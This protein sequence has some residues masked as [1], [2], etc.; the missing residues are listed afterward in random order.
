MINKD[1]IPE[2]DGHGKFLQNLIDI[3]SDLPKKQKQL[4]DYMIEHY[5]TVGVLTLS[6]LAEQANVGTTTAMRLINNLGYESYLDIKKD[7]LDASIQTTP[8]AWWHLQESFKTNKQ[9][10]HTLVEVFNEAKSILEQT[11]T[12]S[13]ITNFDKVRQLILNSNRV[14]ILG[15]R[16][17]KALANYFGYLLEEFYPKVVQLSNETEFVYDRL[18]RFTKD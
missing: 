14:H 17:N 8:S 7:I 11:V 9:K 16:T 15:V 2:I 6:E 3:R 12:P 10:D 1:S 4:C 5:Q 18:L 13:L